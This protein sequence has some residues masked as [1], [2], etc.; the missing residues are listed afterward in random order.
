VPRT[1]GA[2]S[3]KLLSIPLEEEVKEAK[4]DKELKEVPTSTT[5]KLNIFKRAI[6]TINT[7]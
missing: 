4:L 6:N 5:Y 1:K 3:K 7:I 2:L